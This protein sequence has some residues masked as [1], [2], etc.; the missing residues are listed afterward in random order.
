MTYMVIGAGPA[1]VKAAEALRAAE[2]D[3][4]I[5]LVGGE[6]EPPYSRMAIPYLLTESIGEDGTYLHRSDG[7]LDAQGISYVHDRASK[8]FPEGHFVSFESG[9]ERPYTRLLIATGARPIKPPV[10]GLDL[11]GVTHCWTL[12]DARRIA[13]R[14]RSGAD[15]VL[16][17]AGF[18]GTIILEALA[19]RG[20]KLTVIEAEDRM[21][22]RMMN[23][24]AGGMLKRWCESKGVT[25]L[26]ST[27]VE[28]VAEAADGG[29]SVSLNSGTDLR[30]DLVVVAAGVSPN[31]EF[32]AGSGIDV[33]DGIVVDD[34]LKTSAADVYAA[35]DCAQGPDFSGGR[36]VHA[37]QPT[38]V[39][40]GRIAALNMTG[41]ETAYRGS[42]SM[43]VLDTLGLISASFG[44][45]KGVDGGDHAETLDAENYRYL[46]L[47]FDGD[48]LIGGLSIG[49]TENIG[50]IRGLI[51]GR[52]R[53][54]PWKARLIENP[55]QLMEAY[56]ARVHG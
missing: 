16:M 10:P 11:P 55:H 3:A 39:E 29:L 14:A 35:G 19:A 31:I 36:A 49:R 33:A 54:G 51:Q 48:Q 56:V 6:P 30:A 42:L 52:V 53:L 23:A 17:G 26:T 50:V 25:V 4:E 22:P 40:H 15:V 9:V 7:Q 20:V 21:V 43:N 47:E 2:A 46:R 38:A 34:F 13:E 41:S 32:V 18:I 45:W 44:L 5:V 27:R 1:G 28:R 12:D 37:I 8:I 24:A